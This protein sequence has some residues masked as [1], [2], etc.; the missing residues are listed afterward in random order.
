MTRART[1]SRLAMQLPIDKAARASADALLH[2]F[3]RRHPTWPA[4]RALIT[5]ACSVLRRR[6]PWKSSRIP[7]GRHTRIGDDSARARMGIRRTGGALKAPDIEWLRGFKARLATP[8]SPA[9]AADLPAGSGRGSVLRSARRNAKHL[10]VRGSLRH[11]SICA[12]IRCRHTTRR[13]R[14]RASGSKQSSRPT[15]PSLAG[16]R[17]TVALAIRVHLRRAGSARRRQS[18]RRLYGRSEAFGHGRRFCAGP[19]QDLHLGALMRSHG[20]LYAF[21]RRPAPAS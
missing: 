6:R 10:P 9:A 4:D 19:R 7:S 12:S 15:L 13:A 20:R 8:L 17:P 11:R 3:F 14:A 18:A 21:D 1:R 16:R 2:Q 5:E